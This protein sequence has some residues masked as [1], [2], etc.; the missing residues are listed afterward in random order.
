MEIK[1]ANPLTLEE[2]VEALHLAEEGLV[3][4]IEDA[5]LRLRCMKLGLGEIRAR[6]EEV[7]KIGE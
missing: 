3:R 4:E 5:K 6:L 2:E 1:S 7:E